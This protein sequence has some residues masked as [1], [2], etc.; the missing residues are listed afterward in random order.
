M[1]IVVC[2]TTSELEHAILTTLFLSVQ[3]IPT[4]PLRVGWH[5][6]VQVFPP[7]ITRDSRLKPPGSDLIGGRGISPCL[8]LWRGTC[9]GWLSTVNGDPGSTQIL[10]QH[11]GAKS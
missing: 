2:R 10:T 3:K 4:T 5:L 8:V 7:G 11:H 1:C 9:P 6:A